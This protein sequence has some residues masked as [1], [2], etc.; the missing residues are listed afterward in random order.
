MNDR[1]CWTCDAMERYGGSFIKALS[2]AARAAD[3][4]NLI[5]I[6]TAFAEAWKKYETMGLD[7]EN[8]NQGE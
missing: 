5:K 4:E 2:A 6:K 8:E 1:D 3:A 7:L